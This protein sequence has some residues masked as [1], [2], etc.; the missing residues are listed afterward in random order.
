MGN[1]QARTYSLVVSP[2]ELIVQLRPDQRAD[3]L[4]ILTSPRA[5]RADRIREYWAQ[6]DGREIADTLINLEVDLEAR[7]TAIDSLRRLDEGL[8]GGVA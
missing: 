8:R 6:P 4:T 5:V 2:D 7:H 3:V 1:G